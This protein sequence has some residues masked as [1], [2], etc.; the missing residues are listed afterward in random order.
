MPLVALS[1]PI[2]DRSVHTPKFDASSPNNFD[3]VVELDSYA[4][5]LKTPNTPNIDIYTERYDLEYTQVRLN[6]LAVDA[7]LSKMYTVD[8]ARQRGDVSDFMKI[9]LMISLERKIYYN[10][11]NALKRYRS[12][13]H[14]AFPMASAPLPAL[15]LLECTKCSG[16]FELRKLEYT[17]PLARCATMSASRA[18]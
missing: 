1:A 11:A 3:Y 13:R 15:K 2:I 6:V 18:G 7:V 12:T 16:V 14:R 17:V 4:N 5:G 10:L 8:V 9:A